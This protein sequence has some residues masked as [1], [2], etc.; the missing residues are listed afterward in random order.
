MRYLFTIDL[1]DYNDTD[2]IYK[3]P[4]SRAIIIK[5]GKIALV[6]SNKYNYYKFPGGGINESEDKI[7][8][9]IRE[10]KEEVGLIVIKNSIKE[11]GEVKRIQKSN[12][13]QIFYQENYYYLCDVENDLM[14]QNL[15][16][17]EQDEEFILKYVDPQTAIITNYN[18]QDN[19]FRKTM[20][21]RDAKV[22]EILV[23]EGII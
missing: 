21:D 2:V 5:D 6:Y 12:L 4:S 22:L 20:I 15:D 18:H 1:K 9:L 11:Y 10:V 7:E 16:K 8:A 23:K 14:K 13:N 17:Y 3:R 19:L